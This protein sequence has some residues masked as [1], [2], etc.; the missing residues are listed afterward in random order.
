MSNSLIN[1]LIYGAFHLC[2]CPKKSSTFN[3]VIIQRD[4]PRHQYQKSSRLSTKGSWR[5]STRTT[6]VRR[7]DKNGP[8]YHPGY[9]NHTTPASIAKV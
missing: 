2:K 8:Y 5:T 4:G 7:S 9:E 1:P 3:L 6:Q